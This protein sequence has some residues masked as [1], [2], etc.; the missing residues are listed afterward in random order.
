M[1]EFIT[2]TYLTKRRLKAHSY[3]YIYILTHYE[4]LKRTHVYL[5]EE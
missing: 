5:Y 3:T 2:R 4:Q 1:R